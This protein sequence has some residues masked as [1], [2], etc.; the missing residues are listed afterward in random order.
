MI[1]K[2]REKGKERRRVGKKS[3]PENIGL[4]DEIKVNTCKK[5]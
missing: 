2:G 1:R 5:Q 4:K 3:A